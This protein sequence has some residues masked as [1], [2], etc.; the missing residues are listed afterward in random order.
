VA[1]TPII[2]SGAAGVLALGTVLSLSTGGGT[3][4]MVPSTSTLA[5]TAP[6]ADA[7]AARLAKQATFG[8]TPAVIARIKQLGI[9]GWLDEQFATRTSSFADLEAMKVRNS[10]CD[11]E[12]RGVPTCSRVYRDS[13]LPAMRFYKNA[14]EGDDQLR[15]RVALA[16]FNIMPVSA[17]KTTDMAGLAHYQQIMLDKAFG[18]F[19]DLLRT[20]IL[21]GSMAAYLDLASSTAAAPNE[22]MARELMQLFS[23][24]SNALNADGKVRKDANGGLIPTY[25]TKDVSEMARALTGWTYSRYPNTKASETGVNDLTL[26]L[27]ADATRFDS[28]AKTFLGTTVPAGASPQQNVDAVIKRLMN[29]PSTSPRIAALL[30]RALVKANPSGDYISRVSSKFRNNGK[31]VAGDLRAVVRAVLIDKE[32]RTPDTSVAS[33]KLKD[34]I[35]LSTALARTIGVRT[36]GYAFTVRDVQ[37][38]QQYLRAP[39][40]FGDYPPDFPMSLKGRT[41]LSPASKLMTVGSIVERHNFVWQWAMSGDGARSEYATPAWVPTRAPTVQDWTAWEAFGGDIEGMIDRINLLMLANQMTPSQREAL[42]KAMTLVTDTSSNALQAR[43][44]AQTGIF[45]VASSP[46][47]QIDR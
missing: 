24:G 35:L 5:A 12:M 19:S 13:L 18:N 1:N 3:G 7:D 22:N 45:I 42:T 44:R 33:G 6:V 9:D 30:I 27:V 41:V 34:P 16:L 15:Q 46:M 11:I 40:V 23:I 37:M 20:V 17:L 26:P 14:V 43:R 8:A 47:F 39:S 31:N 32:A 4:T 36:D 21:S 2:A 25:T 10:Y 38:G 29:D 28:S